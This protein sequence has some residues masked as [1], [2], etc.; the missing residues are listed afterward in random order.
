MR[1]GPAIGAG[2]VLLLMLRVA[3]RLARHGSRGGG[4]TVVVVLVLLGAVV[5]FAIAQNRGS[6]R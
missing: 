2:L 6:R 1:G 5:V 3:L 4:L